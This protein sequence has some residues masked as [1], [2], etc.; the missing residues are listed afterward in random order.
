MLKTYNGGI[1]ITPSRTPCGTI[2]EAAKRQGFSTGIVATS[3]LTHATPA[4]FYAH[5]PDRDLESDIA[6]FLV[7][8]AGTGLKHLPVDIALGGGACFFRPNGTSS[9][10][11]TDGDDLLEAAKGKG[12]KVLEG[13]A[14][15]RAFREEDA[16]DAPVLGLFADDVRPS[17]SP[18]SSMGRCATRARG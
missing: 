11:R 5:V 6:R 12:V 10:C 1:G 15:L 17:S 16:Q 8:E 14:A 2:L 13:M 18:S 3:R 7:G 4:G 9:S